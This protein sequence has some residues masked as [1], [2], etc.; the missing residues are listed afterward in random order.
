MLLYSW[1]MSLY[2]WNM[3]LYSWNMSLYSWKA[4]L[5]SWNV[6]S[7]FPRLHVGPGNEAITIQVSEYATAQLE[8][9]SV[10]VAGRCYCATEIR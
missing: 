7:L 6:T 4:L 1:N 8:Y 10:Y 9:V 3:S 2:S 5:C